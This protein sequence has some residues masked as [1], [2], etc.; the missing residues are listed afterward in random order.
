M[1]TLITAIVL[2]TTALAAQAHHVWLEQDAQGATLYFGEFGGNLREASPGLLDKFPGPVARRLRPLAAALA[3]GRHDL[4]AAVSG[5]V[6]GPARPDAGL[7]SV[8]GRSHRRRAGAGAGAD[9]CV[10][11]TLI[12]GQR[13]HMCKFHRRISLFF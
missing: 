6:S 7:G 5:R 1:K 2:V 13:W 3:H 4:A 10:A 9:L 11:Q 12:R 8:A